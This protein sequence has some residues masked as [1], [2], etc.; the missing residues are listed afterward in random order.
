MLRISKPEEHSLRLVM[1]LARESG[2][3]TLGDLARDERLPEPT[4]AKLLGR[5]RDA[6]L[7]RALRGRHGGYELA[8]P[9]ERVSVAD[10]LRALGVPVVSAH[11]CRTTRYV[12]EPC[13]R[14][15]DCGLRAVWEHLEIQVG[16]VLRR[17]TVA[18]LLHA[19][20]DVHERINSIWPVVAASAPATESAR[21]D[22]RPAPAAG[23]ALP[24]ADAVVAA[25]AVGS[26]G[27]RHAAVARV[28][29]AQGAD[30]L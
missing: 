24:T 3:Q 30:V 2:Q 11:I 10:V 21:E 7:V 20:R 9:A 6:G 1:R 23:A 13:P 14:L 4:V 27:E 29:S 12:P 17:V 26:V 22:P 25:T 15:P 28:P 16:D 19:E 5:L 18:D 8:L